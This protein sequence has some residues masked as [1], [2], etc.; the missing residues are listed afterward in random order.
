M[1]I[2]KAD[3]KDGSVKTFTDVIA[4]YTKG[5]VFVFI[6]GSSNEQAINI[7]ETKY[8]YIEQEDKP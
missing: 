6:D 5:N 7:D 2:V 4:T 1:I 8:I 3:F